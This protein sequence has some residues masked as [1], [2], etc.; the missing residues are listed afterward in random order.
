[1][2]TLRVCQTAGHKVV[3]SRCP[4]CRQ[5]FTEG[6]YLIVLFDNGVPRGAVAFD[7]VTCCG[8]TGSGPQLFGSSLEAEA[9]AIM[10]SVGSNDL[11]LV[12]LDPKL[13]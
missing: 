12:P 2:K 13:F 4:V 11:E 1:M 6:E 5:V 3:R 8:Q 10:L 7:Q 9:G